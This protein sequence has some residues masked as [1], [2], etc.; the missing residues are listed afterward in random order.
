MAIMIK[1]IYDEVGKDDGVRVLVDRLWPRGLSKEKVK[2]DCWM[3]QVAPSTQLRKWFHHDPEK[4]CEFKERYKEEL[5]NEKEKGLQL[6]ELKSL[7]AEYRNVTLIY[8]AK[9]QRHNQAV[10][11]KEILERQ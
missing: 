3:K 7:V 8:S 2:V 4:F 11:L 9:D 10:V 6:E 1:R 5:M